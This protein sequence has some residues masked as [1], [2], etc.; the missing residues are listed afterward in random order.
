MVE[1]SRQRYK[2]VDASLRKVMQAEM[3][4]RRGA[5]DG[6]SA[7][8]WTASLKTQILDWKRESTPLADSPS[9]TTSSSTD[10]MVTVIR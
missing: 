5:V 9:A 8:N 2:T 3:R 1:E 4:G 6:T 10:T 7:C